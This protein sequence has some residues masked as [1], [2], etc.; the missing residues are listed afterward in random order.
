MRNLLKTT[1][2]SIALL[3]SIYAMAIVLPPDDAKTWDQKTCP[4]NSLACKGSG[5]TC[6]TKKHCP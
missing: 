2:L 1:F 4:D 6:S 3:T 5:N